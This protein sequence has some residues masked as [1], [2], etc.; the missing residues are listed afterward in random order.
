MLQNYVGNSKIPAF[1]VATPYTTNVSEPNNIWMKELQEQ[2]KLVVDRDKMEKQ[3]Y[4]ICKLLSTVGTVHKMETTE[5]LQDIVYTANSGAIMVHLDPSV[6]RRILVSNFKSG[7]RRG[8]TPVI[9]AYYKSLGFEP[10]IV[11]DFNE[12]GEPMYFEGEADLKWIYDNVYIGASGLR[13]NAAALRWIEKE[14]D[15]KII[16]FPQNNEYLYHLDCNVFPLTQESVLMNTSVLDNNK[17]KE[18]EKYCEI[19]PLG[20][21][22]EDQMDFALSGMTNSIKAGELWI[23]P[24]DIAELSKTKDKD[25]YECERDKIEYAEELADEFGLQLV[26]QNVSAFYCGGS[27]LSCHVQHLNQKSFMF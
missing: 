20:D 24:S 4:E 15:C 13:T 3:H 22:D 9:A 17:I 18:I 25:F 2:G 23:M 27:S 26:I 14:F 11:P 16:D 19:I 8:E 12:K 7:P 1:M 5:P 10:V 6:D 21:T